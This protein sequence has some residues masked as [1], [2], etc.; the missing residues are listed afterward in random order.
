M[1]LQYLQDPPDHKGLEADRVNR[2]YGEHQGR[3]EA[4]GLRVPS[5]TLQS[6]V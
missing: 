3:Q 5:L 2:A 6:E 1:N 4:W